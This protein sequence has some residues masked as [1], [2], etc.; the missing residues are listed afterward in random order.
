MH[1]PS[2]ILSLKVL[3]VAQHSKPY[4]SPALVSSG[5][6]L[7][8]LDFDTW[9]HRQQQYDRLFQTHPTGHGSQS[10]LFPPCPTL[11]SVHS[12]PP[13]VELWHTNEHESSVRPE[14]G[15]NTASDS[16]A[17][18]VR[19][20]YRMANAMIV[21]EILPAGIVQSRQLPFPSTALY[22]PGPHGVQ[23]ISFPYS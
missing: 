17:L 3:N 19:A 21:L 2:P 23:N 5:I 1:S 8:T 16:D 13:S 15:K 4:M 18:C 11:H 9:H 22:F 12:R 7:N 10:E 14:E 20:G 6:C